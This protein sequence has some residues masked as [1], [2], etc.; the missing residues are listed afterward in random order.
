METVKLYYQDPHLQHFSARVCACEAAKDGF[1]VTLDATAFYP[2]GGGQACD[3]GILGGVRVLDVQEKEDAICH[4]CDRPLTPGQVVEGQLDWA[5]RFDLMQQ[6]SGEHIVSGLVHS[7]FGHHNVGFHVGSETMEIDFDGPIP[8]E[9]LAVIETKANEAVWKNLPIRCWYPS[10]E[11][12]PNT[13]YRTKKVLPWPVRIVEI[14]GYDAC[15]CCGT[16]VTHTG[17][18]GLIKLISSVKFHAGVR[19]TL[20]CG[21]RA[22][23]LLQQIFEE[24]RQVSQIFSA[25]MPETAAAAR[26][27][28][29]ALAAEKL[30]AN[31]LQSQLFHH[32]AAE[33][34]GQGNVCRFE[35]DLAPA[36]L[37]ELADKIA[38]VCG[39]WAAVL[40]GSDGNYS[41]CIV[42]RHGDVKAIGQAL[43][44]RGGGKPGFFQGS[45]QAARQQVLQ[46]LAEL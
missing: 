22:L 11:E 15:A 35:E 10:R 42:S 43:G 45:L 5:R 26:K 31:T 29:E 32:I 36:Q 44:A 16:H 38:D 23:K 18:I 6:H 46:I 37:R 39:G 20:C 8:P 13:F 17:E 28:A 3:L 21:G 25:K 7:M 12:L 9:A 1:W 19:I 30:R 33:Y 24:N 4:L 14:P 27:T 2:E 34:A 41:I 40:G